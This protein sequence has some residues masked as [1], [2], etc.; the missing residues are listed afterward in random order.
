MGTSQFLKKDVQRIALLDVR[1]FNTDR[2]SGNLLYRQTREQARADR[3][4]AM[5]AGDHC[6]Q[7]T[8]IDHGFCLPESLEC[9]FLEWLYWPQVALPLDPELKQMVLDIDIERDIQVLRNQIP[10]M[11]LRKGMLRM[12]YFAATFL[13]VCVKAGLTLFEIGRIMSESIYEEEPGAQG[14]GEDPEGLTDITELIKCANQAVDLM[15][16]LDNRGGGLERYIPIEGEYPQPLKQGSGPM[17]G[18]PSGR[19]LMSQ[20]SKTMCSKGKT[21]TL[22]EDKQLEFRGEGSEGEE[23]PKQGEATQ[24]FV[25]DFWDGQ[26]GEMGQ[27]NK[28]LRSSLSLSE[29]YHELSYPDVGSLDTPQYQPQSAVQSP[30][31]K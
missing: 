10:Q 30:F 12:Y 7:L 24:P 14:P 19:S 27:Q 17:S 22:P 2:H 6:Y 26:H 29:L 11:I 21:F 1:I 18:G 3:R 28:G 5:I 16:D 20:G 13:K 4:H 25:G 23:S 15:D 8:P 31:N 9:P